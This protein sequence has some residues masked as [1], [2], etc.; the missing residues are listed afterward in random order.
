[1]AETFDV[2]IVGA[3]VAGLAAAGEL[4]RAGLKIVMLEARD[5]IGGRIYTRHDPLCPVP[6]ELGAEFVHGPQEEIFRIVRASRL[7]AVQ[8]TGGHLCY[9]NGGLTDCGDWFGSV[10]E[11]LG[12]M[13]DAKD[14]E[15]ESFEQF[16]KRVDADEGTKLRACGFVEGFNAAR[17]DRISVNALVRQQEA[18]EASGDRMFRLAGGYDAIAKELYGAIPREYLRLHLNT[19]VERVEWRPGEARCGP[20]HAKRAVVT[21]PLGVLKNG[22]AVIDPEPP[23]FRAA[24]DALEMGNAARVVLRFRERF[25]NKREELASMSFLHAEREAGFPIFWS[26]TPLEAP[27]FTAW[28]GGPSAEGYVAPDTIKTLAKLLGMPRAELE[29]Q[30]EAMVHHNWAA[31][32]YACG[33]YSYVRAGGLDKADKIAEPIE[34]TLYFAGEHT[35]ITGNWGTVHGAIASGRRAA[36]QI[37]EGYSGTGTG[38]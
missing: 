25:W 24:L 4:A 35:D 5:R 10:E 16:L 19:P 11:L 2:V 36:L 18:E 9:R 15:D 17:K 8:V 27:I 37:L 12:K 3:G 30:L 33:A 23:V 13:G 32:P 26:S 28:A 38:C 22:R 1:M 31:D 7:L 20:F 34:N 6:I 29:D 21:F 14:R